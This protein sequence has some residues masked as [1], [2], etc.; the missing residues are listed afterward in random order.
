[1]ATQKCEMCGGTMA[2]SLNSEYAV[3]ENCGNSVVADCKELDRIHRI[4]KNADLKMHM[5]SVEE[6]TD[7]INQLNTISF[8]KEAREKI[9]YCESRLLELKEAEKKREEAKGQS[10]KNDGKIGIII[11]VLFL[12]LIGAAIAGAVYIIYHLKAGDLSPTAT[13]IIISVVVMSAVLALI[14][15]I[16]S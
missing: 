10:D 11:L 1:M 12:L 15:K 16:K 6:Y 13:A 9:S 4:Y 7:A 5:N 3:C 2:Y 14:G 8:L